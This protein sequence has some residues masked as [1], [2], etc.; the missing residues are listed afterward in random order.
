MTVGLE[1]LDLR[2]Y[3][4]V[5]M[6]FEELENAIPILYLVKKNLFIFNSNLDIKIP[7]ENNKSPKYSHKTHKS[8]H[9]KNPH[10]IV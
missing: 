2:V 3:R 10:I 7:I 4:V 6:K 8:S 5:L 9:N 1:G